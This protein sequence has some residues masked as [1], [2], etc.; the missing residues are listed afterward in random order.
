MQVATLLLGGALADRGSRQRQMIGADSVA[1]LAQGAI[2]VLLLTR[3]ASFPTL[4]AL[5]VIASVAMALHQPAHVGLVPLVAPRERLQAANALLG[6]ANSTAYALGAVSAGIIAA[7]AG[8]GAELA[9]DAA[10]FAA[11]ALLVLGIRAAPQARSA[12]KSLVRE[13]REGLREF[14]AHTWLWTIVVQFS[15]M[16]MGWFGAFAVLGPVIAKESLGGAEAWGR[17]VGAE[18]LGLVAGGLLALRVHF[19]RTMLA[20]T[21]FCFPI[22]G[23]PLLLS[24]PAPTPLIAAASFVAGVAFGAF[25]VLWNTELHKRVA[26]EALSRVSAYDAM[27]SIALV[28][29]GEALAGLAAASIGAA[30]SAV[31]CAVLIVVPTAAVL[32]VRDVR[33]MRA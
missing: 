22:S 14:T 26:P 31:V 3:S 7:F 15:V 20:A 28:P 11:S 8:A 2:A 32:A 25:G 21:L 29:V 16:L 30:P 1:A 27:G 10:T 18:G 17:I 23:V 5:V 33:Q 24:I 19:A 13:L 9:I 6:I 4:V 12:G